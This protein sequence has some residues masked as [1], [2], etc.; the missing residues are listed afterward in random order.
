M[1]KSKL[2]KLSISSALS[3][4]VLMS[5]GVVANAAVTHPDGGIWDRGLHNGNN[6]Y[7]MAYSYYHHD[8]RKHY[9]WARLGS[10]KTGN[11]WAPAG[12]TSTA[13]TKSLKNTNWDAGYG[14]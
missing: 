7:H 14:F 1:L 5:M 6:N 10:N 11:K 2:K 13:N 3:L 4:S 8:T 12:F 9:S